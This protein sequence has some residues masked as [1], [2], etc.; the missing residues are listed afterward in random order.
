MSSEDTGNDNH[1]IDN[2]DVCLYYFEHSSPSRKVLIALHE[3]N[4]EF[5]K[6]RIDL[7]KKEQHERWYLEKINPRGEVPVLKHGDN[8]IVESSSIMKYIDENLGKKRQQLYPGS[9][10]ISSKV[11]QL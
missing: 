2:Q 7:L 10:S 5:R 1:A 3:K 11:T 9:E 4:V 8:I 6:I